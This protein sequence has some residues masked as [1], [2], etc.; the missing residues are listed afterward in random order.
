M[1]CGKDY[2]DNRF[3]VGK[4]CEWSLEGVMTVKGVLLGLWK[5]NVGIN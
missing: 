4:G 3:G 5:V 2:G 1:G